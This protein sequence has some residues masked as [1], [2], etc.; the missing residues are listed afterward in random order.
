MGQIRAQRP[1][2]KRKIG[3]ATEVFIGL[4]LLVGVF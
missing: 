3:I 1:L 2:K 4:G